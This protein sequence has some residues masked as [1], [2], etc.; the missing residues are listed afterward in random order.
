M[1]ARKMEKTSRINKDKLL[2]EDNARKED[3][4]IKARILKLEN[5]IQRHHSITGLPNASCRTKMT[6]TPI[7]IFHYHQ[8][9]I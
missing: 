7:P 3:N 4:K 5:G 9:V 1:Q 6:V 2:L 8:S